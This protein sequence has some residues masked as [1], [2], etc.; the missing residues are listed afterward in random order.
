MKYEYCWSVFEF[1]RMSE[2]IVICNYY[3]LF[4][5]GMDCATDFRLSFDVTI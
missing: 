4:Y 5:L 3:Y 2:F 1:N